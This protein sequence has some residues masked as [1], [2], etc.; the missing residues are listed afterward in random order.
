M[1][2][3]AKSLARKD[4]VKQLMRVLHNRYHTFSETY[5]SSEKLILKELREMQS[6]C[7]FLSAF[8]Q[9]KNKV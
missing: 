8:L 9:A 3:R 5:G 6:P 7:D 1:S 2:D 4:S